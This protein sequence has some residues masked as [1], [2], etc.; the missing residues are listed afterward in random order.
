MM[1][2]ND[3]T[4]SVSV[5]IGFICVQLALQHSSTETNQQLKPALLVQQHTGQKFEI[6]SLYGATCDVFMH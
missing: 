6:I 5:L 1:P 3:H 4:T 2:S